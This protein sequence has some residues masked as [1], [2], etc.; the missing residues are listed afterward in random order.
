MTG[1]F[2]YVML[3][4]ICFH[5]YEQFWTFYKQ[6]INAAHNNT[7]SALMHDVYVPYVKA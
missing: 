6:G 4:C 5:K 2:P 3:K 7:T 1:G